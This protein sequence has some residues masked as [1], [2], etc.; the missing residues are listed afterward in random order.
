[1]ISKQFA[2]AVAILLPAMALSAQDNAPANAAEA[3]PAAEEQ[4]P[5]LNCCT[6]GQF[7][8]SAQIF[9]SDGAGPAGRVVSDL[10]NL[11]GATLN[12]IMGYMISQ[13]DSYSYELP[14]KTKPSGT[15]Y[16]FDAAYDWTMKPLGS[17]TIE[18]GYR[19]GTIDYD[20]GTKYFSGSILV[21]NGD[22]SYTGRIYGDSFRSVS[23]DTDKFSL[24]ALWRPKGIVGDYL[25]VGL[26]YAHE[27]TNVCYTMGLSLTQEANGYTDAQNIVESFYPDFQT[28]N[29]L[30]HARAGGKTLPWISAG[31]GSWGFV[32]TA[33][34]AAGYSFRSMSDFPLTQ[35][36]NGEMVGNST[37]E[38]GGLVK[39]AWIFEGSA[40]LRFFYNLPKGTITLDAGYAYETDLSGGNNT[41]D[42]DDGSNSNDSGR[43]DL[44]GFVG[45]LGYRCNW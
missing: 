39:D 27:T 45:R 11:T 20:S 21:N 33:D 30:V 32:P 2:S 22:D 28:D 5:A 13:L 14:G 7:S 36:L 43:G 3:S 41:S 19:G 4:A 38:G 9:V 12:I 25:G 16:G 8:A 40:C 42:E 23:I 10:D 17:F 37:M 1:M 35:W 26:G 6:G 34:L 24:L 31:D 29:V 44:Q 15:L 18:A